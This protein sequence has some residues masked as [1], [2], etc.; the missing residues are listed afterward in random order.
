MD[1]YICRKHAEMWME[2]I[3][4]NFQETMTSG[5]QGEKEKKQNGI[6][7]GYKAQLSASALSICFQCFIKEKTP[8]PNTD[9]TPPSHLNLY[10]STEGVRMAGFTLSYING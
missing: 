8:K 1:T 2:R 5:R 7:K 6:K 3:H 10:R 9:K 4:T